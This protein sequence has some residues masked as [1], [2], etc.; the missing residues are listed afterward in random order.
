[1]VVSFAIL[2][3][4]AA[5][6]PQC[7]LTPVASAQFRSSI[8]DLAVDGNDLWAATGYG[9][10]LYDRSVDPPVIVGS[11]AVPGTTRVVRTAN[12]LAYAGSGTFLV[13]IRK[14]SRALVIAGIVDTG[15]TVNDLVVRTNDLFV[16]TSNGIAQ[17]DLLNPNVPVRTPAVFVTSGS[18]VTSL[19]LS[20][21]S[22]LYAA[23]G[24]ASVE[25]FDV[26]IS[27]L[28][29]RVG[30]FNS[31]PR[32]T[33]VHANGGR[34]Y[35]SD[36]QSTDV[37][38]G[39]G[40]SLTPAAAA[41]LAFGSISLSQFSTGAIFAAGSD[42]R[43]RAFDV[44]TAGSPIEVF[45][46]DLSPAGGTVNRITSMVVAGGRLYV[47]AGDIG[48]LTY[49]IG[50]FA[51]PFPLRAYSG[52]ATT[53]VLTL[54]NKVYFSR[55][56]G[57][58]SEF[59]Q[60]ANG[61]LTQAR[62][63][64]GGRVDVIQDGSAE[65]GLL[66]T[67][68]GSSATLWTLTSTIPTAIA[69]TTFRAAVTSAAL[70][71]TTGYALL[72][73]RSLWSADFSQ[74]QP[75][76]QAI[77]INAKPTFLARSG[78]SLV[79][80]DLRDDGTT[81][82]FFFATPDFSATPAPISVPGL[83][84]SGVTLSGKTAAVWTFRGLTLADFGAGSSTLLP[85]SNAFGA[86]AL[87]L[88]GTT[89]V[90]VT[91]SALIAW[92]TAGRRIANQFTLPSAP[93]GVNISPSGTVAN[94]ATTDGVTSV[95]LAG[96]TKMPSLLG[97]ANPNA[98]YKEVTAA[99]GHVDL[100]DSRG[101]D[102]FTS[103]LH[104]VGSVRTPG[105]IDAVAADRGL[106][107]ISSNLL[108]SAYS[109]DGAFQSSIT[110]SEGSDALPLSITT[111][112]GAVWVSI[113]RGCPANC[114]NKTL[115]FDARSGSLTQTDSFSGDVRDVVTRGTSAYVLTEITKEIRL[116]DVSDPYHPKQLVSRSSVGEGV[117]APVS[118]AAAGGTVYVIGDRLYAYAEKDLAKGLEQLVTYPNDS[119]TGVTYIDQHLR[120][121][122]G[123][124]TLTGRGFSP[125][126][127][128]V[129]SPAA[130]TA[131][132]S[133]PVPSPAR[134]L[135]SVAGTIYVLTDHSL[136]VWSAQPLTAPGRRRATR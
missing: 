87:S 12:G 33:S 118:I 67:S 92:D 93:V 36:G 34:V 116:F 89:L 82:L 7:N 42:R 44:T 59:T 22:T 71:G 133:F 28:P 119:S 115:V 60:S 16:A 37:F 64:D 129:G 127:F 96:S 40:I 56:S 100:V 17:F 20:G 9:V 132:P 95:P 11:L 18:N 52:P 84:T 8:F 123:C 32:S 51:Q 108:V 97:T 88:N 27:T 48:L 122:G 54:A 79:L 136:E 43:L 110:I 125:Q 130:W 10:T 114:E 117:H 121:D 86:K 61:S 1:M 45:R 80:A 111:S 6:F 35:V 2:L 109:P 85:Q 38:V 90:E 39:A 126:L 131:A 101:V 26:S 72:A 135:A 53:S 107:T 120:I 55:S 106:Y 83:A 4:A 98:Y 66:L 99:A 29:Q 74:T 62:S 58:I 78:S 49:D 24:D 104:F 128:T 76:P 47:G 21:S 73:D 30:S 25:V 57:G 113:R 69:T 81:A 112:N 15:A 23:D 102:I 19:S 31:L 91:D 70:I 134:S 41:P 3:F 124:A 105:F 13:A 94:L 63:W 46:S 5:A 68:S 65:T 77:A 14:S 103:S 50:A 75:V